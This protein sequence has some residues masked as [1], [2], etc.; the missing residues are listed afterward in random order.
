[1]DDTP[2]I[3]KRWQLAEKI[4]FTTSTQEE[5]GGYCL[6]KETPAFRKKKGE[7]GR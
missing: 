1:M 2:F 3:P 4:S 7:K 6:S 5:G